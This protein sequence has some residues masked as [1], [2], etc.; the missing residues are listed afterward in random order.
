M[1]HVNAGAGSR[2]GRDAAKRTV[3]VQ[4]TDIKNALEPFLPVALEKQSA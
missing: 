2:G 1:S 3:H 4:R